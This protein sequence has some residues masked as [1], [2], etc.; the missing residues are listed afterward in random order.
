MSVLPFSALSSLAAEAGLSL[1]AVSGVGDLVEDGS[2]LT[3]W[4]DAGLA[5]DMSYMKRPAELLASPARLLPSARSIVVVAV[6]YERSPKEPLATGY[7]R[8]ARYAWGRDYHRVLRRRLGELVERV[9]RHLGAAVEHRFFSDSVPLLER[10]LAVRAGLGFIGKNTMAILPKQGSFFFLG[11]VLWNLEIEGLPILP[12]PR[13]H[14]GGCTRCLTSCP[15]NA[16]TRERTLDAARCISYLTIEKR[17]ALRLS[18]REA[19]GEWI[20]GC[21]ICQEVCPFNAAALKRSF[22]ASVPELSREFG[23]GPALDLSEVLQLRSDDAFRARFQGTPLM[24]TKREGLLRN[25]TVV[26]ANTQADRLLPLVMEVA[27][28]DSSLVVRGHALWSAAVMASREGNAALARVRELLERASEDLQE[29]VGLIR[30]SFP[31]L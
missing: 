15:T 4:Q 28:G 12:V 11:E 31:A 7:G 17:G 1:L 29:E 27:N 23:V 16:F 26:A 3:A 21:D 30:A 6:F 20:F 2:R 25:A 18:E 10:A 8:V 5:A 14:C 9:E 24:R 22:G 19:L 13:S